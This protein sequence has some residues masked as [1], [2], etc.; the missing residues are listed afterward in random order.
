MQKRWNKL[1]CDVMIN[2][3]DPPSTVAITPPDTNGG[4][5]AGAG[6]GTRA[7]GD[8]SKASK[9]SGSTSGSGSSSSGGASDAGPLVTPSVNISPKDV[10]RISQLTPKVH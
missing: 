5:G 4:G 2:T 8:S 6:G 1:G 3:V 10:A 9:T 7:S